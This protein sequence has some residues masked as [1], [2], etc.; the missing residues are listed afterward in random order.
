MNFKPLVITVFL[1]TAFGS[2][3]AFQY[4][5]EDTSAFDVAR[6]SSAGNYL[7]STM[8]TTRY[9]VFGED[10]DEVV[11]L[12]AASNGYLE[13]WE[14]N[15]DS[16]NK[17]G[18]KVVVYDLFG[19]GLSDR[20]RVDLDLTVFRDQLDAIINSLDAQRIHLVGSSFGSIIAADYTLHYP[21]RVGKLIAIGPAGW[22]S[23]TNSM[24][25]LNIP[26]LGEFVFHYFG[27]AI[28]KPR[29]EGYFYKGEPQH[30]AVE[31]WERYADYPGFM[32]SYLSTLRHS[33]V[34]DYIDGWRKLGMLNKP[35]MFIWGRQDISFPF[36]NAKKIAVLI[37]HAEIVG[38]EEAAHW[39]NIEQS[40]I[41][42]KTM[43]SFLER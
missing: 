34:F 22:P 19:R 25:A 42:N 14:P 15:I 5:I 7:N 27:K 18:Y 36:T 1:C 13:Q 16:L 40:S 31:K 29:V 33:P 2:I 17:A 4:F 28:L 11:V 3:F 30:W 32:R 12:V 43:L 9:Q 26:I 8:G 24:T 20:P 21:E 35:T 39:V 10:G 41:V 38:I 6:K 37:P 23:D